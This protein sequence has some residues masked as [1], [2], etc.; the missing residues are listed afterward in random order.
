LTDRIEF[1][2]KVNS[3]TDVLNPYD[4]L[5]E[6]EL[7]ILLNQKLSELDQYGE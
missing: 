4:S 3:Q 7:A 1:E 2:V 5:D 6:D